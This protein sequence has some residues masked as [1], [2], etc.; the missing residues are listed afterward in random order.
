MI[1]R[2]PQSLDQNVSVRAILDFQFVSAQESHADER[3]RVGLVNQ[4]ISF[5]AVLY[6]FR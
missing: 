2:A 5:S 1:R 3:V 4:D 6:H